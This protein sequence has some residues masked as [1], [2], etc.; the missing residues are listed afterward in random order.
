MRATA[1]PV[2]FV[3]LEI[4]R[5]RRARAAFKEGLTRDFN[6]ERIEE[7][8]QSED[9]DTKTKAAVPDNL[10]PDIPAIDAEDIQAADEENFREAVQEAGKLG[11]EAPEN[12]NKHSNTSFWMSNIFAKLMGGSTKDT[13]ETTSY[14]GHGKDRE[15]A[16][17]IH[18]HE[19]D[20]GDNENEDEDGWVFA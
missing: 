18:K 15:G 9:F 10:F 2:D 19:D 12:T 13:S 20:E 14:K 4:I 11:A 8:E 16:G 5:E 3:N 6:I 1:S 7:D 17:S